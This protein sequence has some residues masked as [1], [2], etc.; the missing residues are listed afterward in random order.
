MERVSG[1]VGYS[2]AEPIR[3]ALNA[4]GIPQEM[5]DDPELKEKPTN[6][7]F[8]NKSPRQ[9]MQ[10]LG[11]EFGR[12]MVSQSIWIDHLIERIRTAAT[13]NIVIDDVRFDNEVEALKL[14]GGYIVEVKRDDSYYELNDVH[15]S[16]HGVSDHLI[17]YTFDNLS[18]YLNDL[19][20][21]VA[22]MLAKIQVEE[23]ARV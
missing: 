6:Y 3:K 14:E 19:D 23:M 13:E 9:L 5:L 22:N 10:L 4:M 2:F 11:T 18:C 15:I 1:Y 21:C 8:G 17:D 20:I 12:D 16:E 7:V